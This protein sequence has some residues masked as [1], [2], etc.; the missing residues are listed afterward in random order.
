MDL[1]VRLFLIMYSIILRDNTEV[2][3]ILGDSQQASITLYY[4]DLF[5]LYRTY[6][7]NVLRQ[8][9]EADCEV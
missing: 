3:I 9:R 5:K 7:Y 1:C 2:V 4:N 8:T 6:Q